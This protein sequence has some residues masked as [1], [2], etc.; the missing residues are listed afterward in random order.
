[1]IQEVFLPLGLLCKIANSVY[2]T[3]FENLGDPFNKYT[4]K[5]PQITNTDIG[6]HYA[7]FVKLLLSFLAHV[8]PMIFFIETPLSGNPFSLCD[9]TF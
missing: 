6:S 7:N 3:L 4:V 1:M 2:I 9:L 5:I 8:S